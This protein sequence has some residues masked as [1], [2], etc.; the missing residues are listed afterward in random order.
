M[1]IA[2]RSMFLAIARLLWAFDFKRVKDENGNEIVPDADALTNGVLVHPEEFPI[3]IAARS[4]KRAQTVRAEWAK[5]E[6]K[7][8][9][10]GQWKRV[11]EEMFSKEYVP[12]LGREKDREGTG[13]N[14]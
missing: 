14:E 12:L 11:P 9:D 4:E 6:E 2:E 3:E 8:N 13:D 7:L 10:E 5:V 1:H